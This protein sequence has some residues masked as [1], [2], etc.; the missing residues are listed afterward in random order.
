[1]PHWRHG[2]LFWSLTAKLSSVLLHL[3]Y[4][5]LLSYT[6]MSNSL[7]RHGLQPTRF[8]CP[9]NFLGKNTGVGCHFLLQRIFPTQGSNLNLLRLLHWQAVS[10]PLSHLGSLFI[11]KVVRA[12][13]HA[14]LLQ[15]CLTLWPHRRQPTRLLCPWGSPGKNTGVGCHFLLPGDLPNPGIKPASLAL[16]ADSLP[17]EPQGKPKNIGVGRLS[18][19]QRIFPTQELNQ[20]LLHCRQILYQLS[21]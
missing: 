9:C 2:Y 8:L 16:Q 21:Y 7:W 4:V 3:L 20:G 1:M 19:L 13:V 10:L 18:L 15:S 11:S 17:T 6:V 12:C 14:K 5:C